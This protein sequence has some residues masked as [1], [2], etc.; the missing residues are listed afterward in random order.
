[1]FEPESLVNMEHT[2]A[3]DAVRRERRAIGDLIS[4][5]SPENQARRIIVRSVAVAVPLVVAVFIG[6]V[7]LALHDQ[8][9]DW[10]AWLAMAAAV[11]VIAGVFAGTL[12]GFVRTSYLFD[13]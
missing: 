12:A 1:M 7:A 8:Q 13:R 4:K 11:G 3:D 5:R 6:I 2:T 10:S 9:P